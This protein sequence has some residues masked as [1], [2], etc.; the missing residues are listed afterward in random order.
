MKTLC[1]AI[2]WCVLAA[3]A[4]VGCRVDN[5]PRRVAKMYNPSSAHQRKQLIVSHI[6]ARYHYAGRIAYVDLRIANSRLMAVYLPI[7]FK[8]ELPKNYLPQCPLYK[9]DDLKQGE[10]SLT[11]AQVDQFIRLVKQSGF[12][13]LGRYIGM[14]KDEPTPIALISIKLNRKART[15]EYGG[16][17]SAPAFMEVQRWLIKTAS[18]RFKDFPISE[19]EKL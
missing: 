5:A 19:T 2:C 13:K 3:C 15:V 1:F 17:T 14:P 7:T 9:P 18:S 8:S 16:D 12:F 10:A 6:D 4:L 11:D